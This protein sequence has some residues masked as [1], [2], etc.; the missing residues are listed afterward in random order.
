M[1]DTHRQR[2]FTLVEAMIVGAILAIVTLVGI[3]EMRTLMVSQRVRAASSDVLSTML[4]ARSEAVKRNAT[5]AVVPVDASWTK[6]WRIQISGRGTLLRSHGGIGTI[7]AS[8]P[9]T[10]IRYGA[11]GRLSGGAEKIQLT[12]DYGAV[13]RCVR[14]DTSGRPHLTARACS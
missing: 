3:P 10:G 4:Y 12:G 8:G 14:V 1:M 11:N 9:S 6:G 7:S 5:V 2:G 13:A